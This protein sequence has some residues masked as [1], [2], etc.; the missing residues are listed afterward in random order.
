MLKL[1]ISGASV[2]DGE[3]R[4]HVTYLFCRSYVFEINK[5]V[6]TAVAKIIVSTHT[7]VIA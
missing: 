5:I 7:N 3:K 4:R 6:I 2:L 1:K